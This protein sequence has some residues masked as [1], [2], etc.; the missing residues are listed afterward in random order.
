MGL[1]W[2]NLV[3]V[4]L[5]LYIPYMYMLSSL[6][7]CVFRLIVVFSIT[8]YGADQFQAK[9]L[10]LFSVLPHYCSLHVTL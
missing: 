7:F 9:V 5:R 1:R 8:G 3:S 2:C 10:I 6:S 4:A